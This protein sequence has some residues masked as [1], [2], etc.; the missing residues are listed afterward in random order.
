MRRL[1]ALL[2]V[3]GRI[4]LHDP[5]LHKF[6][7][8]Q[9][10]NQDT[11]TRVSGA[12]LESERGRRRSLPPR[13]SLSRL[14]GRDTA[15]TTGECQSS[16]R[17][18]R[19]TASTSRA[20][21]GEREP[22]FSVPKDAEKKGTRKACARAGLTAEVLLRPPSE[23]NGSTRPRGYSTVSECAHGGKYR[24]PQGVNEPA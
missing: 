22:Q 12:F 10:R 14:F 23:R 4:V 16:C 20:C 11:K 9:F 17:W 19:V 21:Q 24:L 15:C 6:S 7:Q 18:T 5:G 2:V 13:H 3:Q 8:L 1:A